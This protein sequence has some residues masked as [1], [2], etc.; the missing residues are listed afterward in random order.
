MSKCEPKHTAD[1]YSKFVE[2]NIHK[3]C[4]LHRN[5][6]LRLIWRFK[7]STIKLRQM[8]ASRW[9]LTVT[10]I[11]LVYVKIVMELTSLADEGSD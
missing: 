2:L 6:Y 3:Q 5:N 8:E 11:I 10:Y 4:D 9:I 7:K 1:I